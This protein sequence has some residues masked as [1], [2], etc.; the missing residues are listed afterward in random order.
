MWVIWSSVGKDSSSSQI[1]AVTLQREIKTY[2]DDK[3]HLGIKMPNMA[4]VWSSQ[5]AVGEAVWITEES[6][7]RILHW[8]SERCVN[9]L[10]FDFTFQDFLF[11]SYICCHWAEQRVNPV[12][13]SGCIVLPFLFLRGKRG[14]HGKACEKDALFCD[15]NI[16]QYYN[17]LKW[18][19]KPAHL[20]WGIF[21]VQR[22]W[23]FSLS[24]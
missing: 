14:G 24:N 19:V 22:I 12:E 18:N 11:C 7:F 13:C 5:R 4:W 2:L 23:R 10:G 8:G 1:S 20:P 3:G 9:H 6:I 21:N 17:I 16:M 15:K